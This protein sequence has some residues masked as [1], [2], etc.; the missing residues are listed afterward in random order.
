[1]KFITMAV[2]ALAFTVSAQAKTTKVPGEKVSRTS[3]SSDTS[4]TSS[5]SSYGGSYTHEILTN[6]TTGSYFSEKLCKDCDTAS[7]L[8]IGASYL[9]YWKDNMQWGAEGS[10]RTL[11]KE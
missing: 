1:M 10:I 5:Y 9:H 3:S 11:S 6:L 2:M 8:S 4:Y 7:V